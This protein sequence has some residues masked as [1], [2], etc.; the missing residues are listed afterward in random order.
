MNRN[1]LLLIICSLLGCVSA[2]QPTPLERAQLVYHQQY[3]LA[4][5][6]EWTEQDGGFTVSFYDRESMRAVEMNFD[7]KGRWRETTLS[8]ETEQLSDE[9]LHYVD[10]NFEKYYTTAYELRRKR[11]RFFYGLVVDT[12]THIYTLLFRENG[13]LVEEYREGIDGGGL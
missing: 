1:L 7:N 4:E 5:A 12:P 3:P 6:A 9:I 2:A 8:L 11:N 10:S 13:S